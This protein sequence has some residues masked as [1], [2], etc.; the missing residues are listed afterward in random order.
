MKCSVVW[1]L[2]VDPSEPVPRRL[3][4]NVPFTVV[5]FWLTPPQ[6]VNLPVKLGRLASSSGTALNLPVG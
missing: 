2:T 6:I 1:K 5:P 3:K 4:V